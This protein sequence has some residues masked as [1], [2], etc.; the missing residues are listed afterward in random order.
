MFYYFESIFSVLMISLNKKAHSRKNE[1]LMYL[2]T[3]NLSADVEI[4]SA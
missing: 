1:L 3:H 4:F 2:H